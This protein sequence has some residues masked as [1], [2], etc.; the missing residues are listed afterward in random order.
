MNYKK[1]VCCSLSAWCVS[2]ILYTEAPKAQASGSFS[3]SADKTT[4][5]AGDEITISVAING[6]FANYEYKFI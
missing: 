6:S 2:G 1:I 5:Y 3:L 4:V